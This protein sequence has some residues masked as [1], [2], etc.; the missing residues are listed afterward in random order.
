MFS[1]LAPSTS[2]RKQRCA[3]LTN[4]ADSR[5]PA[6][7]FD[8]VSHMHHEIRTP[9]NAVIGFADLM[10]REMFGALGDSRYREYAHHILDSGARLLRITEQTLTMAA[11]VNDAGDRGGQT[12]AL[13]DLVHDALFP[14]GLTAASPERSPCRTV[15]TDIADG[16]MIRAD[17]TATRLALETLIAGALA[18]ATPCAKLSIRASSSFGR[19]SLSLTLEPSASG[20]D[21]VTRGGAGIS[22][23]AIARELLR[24]QRIVLVDGG[25]HGQHWGMEIQFEEARQ[26]E[27]L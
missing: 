1:E 11:L 17:A 26:A 8:I 23:I 14:L 7:L 13:A 5:L 2:T 27:L 25:Q 4:G 15:E 24:L 16:L 22:D 18:T 9:L 12:V 10:Q 3:G 19:T 20:R 21:T 6:D